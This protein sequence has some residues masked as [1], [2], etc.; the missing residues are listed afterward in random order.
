MLLAAHI[1]EL[2]RRPLFRTKLNE[3]FMLGARNQAFTTDTYP[4]WKP[5]KAC[6]W[7]PQLTR[8]KYCEADPFDFF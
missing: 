3:Q 6:R 7:N 8:K 2:H 4:D 5:S 1:D